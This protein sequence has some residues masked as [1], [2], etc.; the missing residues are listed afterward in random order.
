MSKTGI[1][2]A[3]LA[4]ALIASLCGN[5]KQYLDG[6]AWAREFDAYVRMVELD[7]LARRENLT[8]V[9]RLA[10]SKLIEEGK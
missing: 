8:T 4:V 10:V 9:Q 3:T 7:D 2:F 6:R 1:A 5:A